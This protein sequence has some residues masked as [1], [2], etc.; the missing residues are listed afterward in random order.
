M[1]KKSIKSQE[2]FLSE[3]EKNILRKMFKVHLKKILELK[4]TQA[5]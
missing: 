4:S 2:K 5:G 1:E 3:E